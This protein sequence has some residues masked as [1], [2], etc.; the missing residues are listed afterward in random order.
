MGK[1]PAVASDGLFSE[2]I[3]FGYRCAAEPSL[4]P[5]FIEQLVSRSGSRSGRML[6]LN[7]TA[8]EVL[9]SVKFNIDDAFHRQYVEYY[10]NLCPWRPELKRK[11]A[12]RFY[13]TYHDFSVPQRDFYHTEFFNDWAGPQDVH[14]GMLGTIAQSERETV[15]LLLQRTRQQGAYSPA[16]T[17]AFNDLIPH[18]RRILKLG[19]EFTRQRLVDAAAL[20]AAQESPDPFLLLDQ[21]ARISYLSSEA[22]AL[23]EACEP[24]RIQ[25]Q[26]L[27]VSGSSGRDL[28]RL[29][30]SCLNAS[31]GQ[32]AQAGGSLRLSDPAGGSLIVTALPI[33]PD[34]PLLALERIG[35][36]ALFFHAP[37][38]VPSLCWK[39]LRD[40]YGFTPAE[41]S[42]AI[43]LVAGE[44]LTAIAEQGGV[45]LNTIRSHLKSLFRKTGVG[46]QPE[47]VMHL[48]SGP[49]LRR[50]A[51]TPL[52]LS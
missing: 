37:G 3:E 10:V 31:M 48:L 45:S 19:R 15:Q 24:L 32:W 1:L 29:I 36:V 8:D 52:K 23:I 5:E 27:E 28:R 46:R 25:S 43:Q 9:D 20:E 13:S 6:V 40:V 11:Q 41:S 17:D 38:R 34:H 42:L 26:K 47:L 51:V 50:S 35:F 4:W 14:H 33:H 16:E 2:L 30:D 21:S 44:T 12:G 49:A 7:P 22:Q 39:T 18:L